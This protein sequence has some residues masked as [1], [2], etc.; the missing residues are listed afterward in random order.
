[1]PI[2]WAA[3][4]IPDI[5]SGMF[6]AHGQ[7]QQNKMNRELARETMAFQER[8]SNTAAQRST[9]DFRKAGLNPA[10]AYERT[11]STPG[12]ATATAGSPL[13]AGISSAKASSQFRQ[14]M[15]IARQQNAADVAL[16]TAQT[17]NLVSSA[18][19]IRQRIAFTALAQPFEL[20]HG[21]ATA[22]LQEYL[23]PAARNEAQW[24]EIMGKW[25]PAL[26]TAKNVSSLFQPFKFNFPSSTTNINKTFKV[27]K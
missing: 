1:M 6:G 5:I 14:D 8:M 3:S 10:L 26:S 9:E 27:T 22:A 12:G 25:A 7:I 20:R 21:K 24:A 11:A 17:D 2:D 4:I 15:E 13:S 16:K 23:L 18:N 19:E